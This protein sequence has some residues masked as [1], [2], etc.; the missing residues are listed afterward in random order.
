MC[1]E[2]ERECKR[3]VAYKHIYEREREC[4]RFVAYMRIYIYM[5]VCE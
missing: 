2:R 5:Y 3:F 4:K 1:V